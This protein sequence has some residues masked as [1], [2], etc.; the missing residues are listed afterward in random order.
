MTFAKGL[1]ALLN[2]KEFA[3][4]V[5]LALEANAIGGRHGLDLSEQYRG[6]GYRLGRPLCQG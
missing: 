4:P 5:G 6:S 3:S 1:S 2:G